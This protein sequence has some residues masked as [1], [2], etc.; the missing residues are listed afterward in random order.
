MSLLVSSDFIVVTS[1]MSELPAVPAIFYNI[2]TRH[3]SCYSEAICL[4]PQTLIMYE[5]DNS[6]RKPE[7]T[8]RVLLTLTTHELNNS[9]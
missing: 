8:N 1:D 3:I 9:D 2:F 7:S 4:L 6:V 5:L